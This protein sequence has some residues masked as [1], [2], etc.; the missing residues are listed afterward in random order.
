MNQRRTLSQSAAQTMLID[1]SAQ[2]TFVLLFRTSVQS[3]RIEKVS[4]GQLYVFVLQQDSKG[5]HRL[6]WGAGALNGMSLNPT[7]N[8]VTVQ[9][10]VG[11]PEGILRSITPGTWT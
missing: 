7:P 4:P 8:S 11:T 5:N 3:L 2:E 10:F 6:N 1:A 9:C